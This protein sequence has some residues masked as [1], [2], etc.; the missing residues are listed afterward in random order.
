[1]RADGGEGTLGVILPS[2]VQSQSKAQREGA[3]ESLQQYSSGL[4]LAVAGQVGVW[5]W[6]AGLAITPGT[7]HSRSSYGIFNR[8]CI[9]NHWDREI[10]PLD[11]ERVPDHGCP[12]GYRSLQ[13]KSTHT[14]G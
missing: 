11:T 2:A 14:C 1:M 3:F 7:V 12:D 9:R 5:L 6:L 13:S 4:P 8:R 10:T